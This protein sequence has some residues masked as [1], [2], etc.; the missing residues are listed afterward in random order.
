MVSGS[1]YVN[2]TLMGITARAD[3]VRPQIMR[4]KVLA[5]QCLK[6]RDGI[7]QRGRLIPLCRCLSVITPDVS[8]KSIWDFLSLLALTQ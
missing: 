3:S 7:L 4:A 5:C 8:V 1:C 6:K 2:D